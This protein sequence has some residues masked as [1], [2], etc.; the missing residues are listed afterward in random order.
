MKIIQ[1]TDLHIG[2]EGE[3]T[4]GIDVRQNF[5][6]IL[7]SIKQLKADHIVITGDLCY[8]GGEIE[9]YKWIKNLI[10][11]LN[12][13]YDIIGGNH[14]DSAL[15]AS[16]FQKEDHLKEGV[17]FFRK[18]LGGT[19]CFF[20]DTATGHIS[21]SQ[22]DWLKME[23]NNIKTPFIIFM[24]YPPVYAN[25]PYLEKKNHLINKNELQEILLHS[26]VPTTIFCGHF[27]VDKTIHFKNIVTHI[28]P[29]CYIQFDW[30]SENFKIDHHK[31][32]LREIEISE[33]SVFSTLT[34][35]KGN[36]T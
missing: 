22:I 11:D 30:R 3:E 31:I 14:D 9:T 21:K 8:S 29:S 1:I 33:T 6:D 34:Y 36:K 25:V 27:H 16:V 7:E 5:L 12:I 13:P 18:E 23:L 10:D 17:L 28:T 32:A 20:L 15:I 19:A 4:R 26:G 24:H 35:L 2:E